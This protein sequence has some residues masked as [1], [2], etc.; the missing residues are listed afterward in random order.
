MDVFQR[1]RWTAEKLVVSAKQQAAMLA[2]FDGNIRRPHVV[3]LSRR[4]DET[5][6]VG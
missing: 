4:L 3:E 5:G 1:I 6:F 2:F